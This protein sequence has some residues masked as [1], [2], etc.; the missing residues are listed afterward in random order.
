MKALPI[1]QCSLHNEERK[2]IYSI[3]IEQDKPLV[4]KDGATLQMKF[5]CPKCNKILLRELGYEFK[6]DKHGR[7]RGSD[8]V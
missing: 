5:E 8:I 4:L 7:G 1:N 2:W 6:K 3:D